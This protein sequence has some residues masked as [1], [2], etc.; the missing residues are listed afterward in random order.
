[1]NPIEAYRDVLQNIEAAVAEVW[2]ADAELTNHAVSRAYEAAINRYRAE[3]LQ[4][5]PKPAG[6]TGLDALVYERVCEICEWRL[7]RQPDPEMPELKPI[8]VE[9]LV[10]CLRKLH[11]SVA[12]W[13]KQGGRQGYLQ[14][15]EKFV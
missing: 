6:L 11:K 5:T 15:I 4:F 13:T 7:G 3:A 12:F 1:M 14:F 10:A 9:D 8:P 2:R